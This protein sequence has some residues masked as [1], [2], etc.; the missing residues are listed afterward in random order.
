MENEISWNPKTPSYSRHTHITTKT[1]CPYFKW[2]VRIRI[3]CQK[4][5]GLQLLKLRDILR[6][7]S[8]QHAGTGRPALGSDEWSGFVV[9]H[10]VIYFGNTNVKITA[11]WRGEGQGNITSW[12]SGNGLN[13]TMQL[14]VRFTVVRNFGTEFIFCEL[15][16]RWHAV[17]S[18]CVGGMLQWFLGSFLQYTTSNWNFVL[19]NW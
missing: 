14:D 15:C 5:V 10:I 17:C 9:C 12:I 16:G 1:N 8:M 4:A 19:R 11:T 6:C 7:W 13:L 2:A 18:V 3:C